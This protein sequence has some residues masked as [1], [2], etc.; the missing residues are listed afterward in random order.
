MLFL[1]CYVV[2]VDIV[3]APVVVVVVIDFDLDG[4]DDVVVPVDID[5]PQCSG[6][7]RSFCC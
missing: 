3:S 2:V 1:C 5:V 7:C 6:C 4:D